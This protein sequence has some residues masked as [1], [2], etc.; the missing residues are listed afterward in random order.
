MSEDQKKSIV[1]VSVS[2]LKPWP[3]NP[4]DHGEDDVVAI[5][6]SIKVFGFTNAI[7]VQS[8]T[9]RIIAG[10]GRLQAAKLL[11]MKEVPVVYLD[12]ADPDADALTVADNRLAENSR[13]NIPKLKDLGAELSGKNYDITLT[14]FSLEE[15]DRFMAYEK[16]DGKAPQQQSS[17]REGR[18]VVCPRCNHEFEA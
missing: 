2:A 8:G 4:R 3:G 9:N 12:I 10:H 1:Y 18:P 7:Q 16:V 15:F 17:T 14:G 5:V 11:G 13:W 6:R